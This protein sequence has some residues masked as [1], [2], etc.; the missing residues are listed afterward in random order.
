[1]VIQVGME[2]DT[3]EVLFIIGRPL[4]VLLGGSVVL[5]PKNI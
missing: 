1:M 3:T 4:L 5:K 2:P